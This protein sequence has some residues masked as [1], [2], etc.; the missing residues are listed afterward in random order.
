MAHE[1]V[2]LAITGGGTGGHLSPAVAV[3][4]V[5]QSLAGRE[6]ELLYLGS[7]D[8][9]E[10]RVIPVMGVR[11]VAISTG[12]LRRYLSVENLVD[13]F[14]VPLG[15][16][17]SLVHLARFRPGALLATGGYVSVPPVIAAW[18]LRR[19]VLLHEQT[20]SL[21]LANRINARFATQVALSVP[22]SERG[23][24]GTNWVLTGNPIRSVVRDGSR[25]RAA[26]RFQLDLALPTV[27]VTGGAQG[28]HAINKLVRGSLPEL[29]ERV[30]LIHQCGDSG[31]TNADYEA[32]LQQAY[33]LP[34]DVR[35]RYVLLR[36]IGQEIGDVYAISDLVVGRAGAGTVN[37]IAALR[38][39][40]ILIPL[41][42]AAGDEQRHNARRLAERGAAVVL[43]EAELTPESFAESVLTLATDRERL[44]QMSRAAG[45]SSFDDPARHIANLLL[46]L[47]GAP[48]LGA[49]TQP[50]T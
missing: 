27:Y 31:G 8:G 35:G 37:E 11:Y 47:A 48:G 22:G 4:E 36:Y 30:Q 46:R 2:K 25:E 19:P 13:L 29:L 43:E 7:R 17:Q 42:H 9:A 49:A 1:R 3:I 50:E 20:G 40:S 39:P 23:L 28:A 12:K 16:A 44:D 10:A 34:A 15:V 24:R 26:R 6:L 14:R 21:G 5:L 18:C 41:P 38:K 45:D 32:L 33:D